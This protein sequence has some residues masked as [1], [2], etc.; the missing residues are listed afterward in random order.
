M[1]L[2]LS[3]YIQNQNSVSHVPVTGSEQTYGNAGTS[4]GGKTLSDFAPGSSFSGQVVEVK[5]G[6]VTIQLSDS[7]LVSANLKAGISLAAGSQVTFLVNSN[8]NN[9]I[10]LSPLFTNLSTSP[11]VE[12]ALKAA[13]LPINSQTAGMVS[14]MMEQGMGIDKNSLLAMYKQVVNHPEVD[15]GMV[16][17]LTQMHLAVNELNAE[18]LRA[19]D[20]LNHQLS[21]SIMEI[22]DGLQQVFANADHAD[23]ES[24]LRLFDGMV[25]VLE[26]PEG[27]VPE[28]AGIDQRAEGGPM[29]QTIFDEKSLQELSGM[30]KNAGADEAMLVMV[31]KGE[32]SAKEVLQYINRL[33]QEQLPAT[34]DRTARN[35]EMQS[36]TAQNMAA[37]GMDDAAARG[38]NQTALWKELLSEPAVGRLFKEVLQKNWLMEPK[39]VA[40]KEKVDSFFEQLKTQ[41]GK[42]AVLTSSVL[43]KDAALTQ[44]TNRLA[45]NM[46]FMNQLNQ[47]F[48]YVQIPLK[49][50]GQNA[51]G[52][53]YV[54]TNKKNLATKDGN[55][56]AFLH[57]DMDHLGSVD[58]YVTME[59]QKV[60][61]NFKVRDDEVLDLIEA[62]ID[63]LNE[64][65]QNRGYRLR[66]TVEKQEEE[67]SVLGEMQK[68]MG[69]SSLPVAHYAFDARA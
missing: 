25:Q 22:A 51:N 58:V 53:L 55:V 14:D 67:I 69:Q 50:S 64:R 47:T 54:Y 57:L 6:T 10:V 45:Q 13:E 37:S 65:L 7:S 9:Q 23:M 17:R 24:M 34:A 20:N 52:D 56:S 21:G 48:T 33:A 60:S 38:Q 1:S 44:S 42:M 19:Y 30:L 68:Q 63:W 16:V 66:A 15:S 46:D 3:N 62:N 28:N 2:Q 61:T 59:Q 27:N 11:N 31:E 26:T 36:Q 43:G 40:D 39:D 41:T 35:Q 49:M 5:D 4:T 12:N 8:Q 18:Q 32:I 29:L